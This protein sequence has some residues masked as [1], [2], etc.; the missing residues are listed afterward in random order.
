MTANDLQLPLSHCVD[1]NMKDLAIIV[2]G[3][4]YK[5]NNII[6]DGDNAHR[7]PEIFQREKEKDEGNYQGAI[8]EIQRKGFF[9]PVIKSDYS[10]LYPSVMAT[11]NFSPDTTTIIDYKSYDKDA[12]K[13]EEKDDH[14]I[15]YIPDN[16]L[17]KTVIIKV[18]KEEGFASSAVRHRLDNRAEYK[19]KAKETGEKHYK[20]L[21]NIEKVK[22]NGGMYG[23]QGNAK[24]PFGYVPIAIATCGISREAMKL[25]MSTIDHFHPNSL[26]ETD[27]DGQYFSPESTYDKQAI[28]KEFDKRIKKKFKQDLTL[29]IDFDDYDCGYFYKAKNYVL[30]N[31]DVLELHGAIMKASSKCDLERKLINDIAWAVIKQEDTTKIVNKYKN[32]DNVELRDFVM[33]KTL[34]KSI[35][36]YKSKSSLSYRLAS[37]AL[38]DLKLPPEQGNQY[39]YVKTTYGYD[40][41]QNVRRSHIDNKYYKEKIDNLLDIFGV[42]HQSFASVSN[43]YGTDDSEDDWGDEGE[44]NEGLIDFY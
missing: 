29:K 10:S 8:V 23:S 26:I 28:I 27:T 11:F 18:D 12:F 20:A 33:S 39:Y 21:S 5:E 24:H 17:K 38:I 4:L 35:N 14:Y 15:Y 25:L 6:A 9:E 1:L 13:I 22:A 30:R 41:Y 7:F 31:G 37:K 36:D 32:F 44:T 3:R 2:M 43:F 34:G 16:V 40:L 19:R 42:S